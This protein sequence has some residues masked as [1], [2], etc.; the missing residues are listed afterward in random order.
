MTLQQK[1]EPL[2]SAYVEITPKTY[3][4][5]RPKVEFPCIVWQEDGENS[6]EAGNIKAEQAI[7]G[8]TD[9]F[10]QEEYDPAIDGIQAAHNALKIAWELSSVQYEEETNLIHYEWR[11]EVM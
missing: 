8:T 5:L 11:W 3:H 4:Y 6:F 10:T 9:Y 1:L 2:V 7:T